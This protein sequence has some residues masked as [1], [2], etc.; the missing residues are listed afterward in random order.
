M[1][2]SCK[3]KCRIQ[4]NNWSENR[5]WIKTT[6]GILVWW[7]ER[8][9]FTRTDPKSK[10]ADEREI[11]T[12]EREKEEESKNRAPH[13][14]NVYIEGVLDHHFCPPYVC[15]S[16]MLTV[17]CVVFLWW[18][19]NVQ[20]CPVEVKGHD[21]LLQGSPGHSLT[22]WGEESHPLQ[23]HNCFFIKVNFNSVINDI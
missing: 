15:V 18:R 21:G 3:Q 17:V 10:P 20:K 2:P 11:Q 8:D 1:L 12:N 5:P 9:G 6:R 13:C 19:C 16:L 22:C 4:T 14:S 23:T 7:R